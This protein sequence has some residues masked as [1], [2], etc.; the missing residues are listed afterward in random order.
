MPELPEVETL[1]RGLLS[2]EGDTLQRVECCRTS[3]MPN[4]ER[5]DQI[6]GHEVIR[7]SRHGKHLLFLFRPGTVLDVHLGMSG[8][9]GWHPSRHVRLTLHWSAS[10]PLYVNDPRTWGRLRIWSDINLATARLGPDAPWE[11]H[12]LETAPRQ[13][14]SRS[15]KTILL[16]QSVLAGLGNIYTDEALLLGG[17]HPARQLSSISAAERH[18]LVEAI[19]EVLR[20]GLQHGGTTLRDYRNPEGQQGRNQDTLRVYGRT[21][22]PCPFCG[23]PI[24]KIT[25]SGRGTHFCAHCQ[26]FASDHK[27]HLTA[28]DI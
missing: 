24:Q 18:K 14:S 16:D 4:P 21:G 9:L 17:I 11:P 15:I 10:P 23:H 27:T 13:T 26:P 19:S 7:L 25:L 8:H 1:R 6:R 20:Q 22:Q 12:L 2:L 5:L 3:I 28:A